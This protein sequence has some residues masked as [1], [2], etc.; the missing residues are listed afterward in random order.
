MA[1]FEVFINYYQGFLI[2]FFMNK[3]LVRQKIVS[4]WIDIASV[5]LIG[6]F[7]NV[8]Q[9]IPEKISDT[10]IFIF[11]FLHATITRRGGWWQRVLWTLICAAVMNVVIIFMTN[12]FLQNVTES[13]IMTPTSARVGYVIST[14]IVLTFVLM[15][16]AWIGAQQAIEF[17]TPSSVVALVGSFLMAFAAS[18]FLYLY[19][20]H[21]PENE[22]FLF[23]VY[24]CLLG[25]VILTLLLYYIIVHAARNQHMTEMQLQTMS[26]HTNHQQEMAAIYHDM[27]VMQHDMKHQVNAIMQ[28]IQNTPDVD[29][30]VVMALLQRSVPAVTLYM[31]GCTVVDAI[32]TAKHA[33]M[34]QHG[35]RFDFQPYPLQKLPLDDTAFCI[36]LSNIL[37][38]AIEG[39]QRIDDVSV[40]KEISLSFAR[41]W[42][43]FYLTCSNTMNPKT[44]QQV[45]DRFITSKAN[46]QIHGLGLESIHQIV[47]R[48]QGTCNISIEGLRFNIDIVLPDKEE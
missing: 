42:S 43:M 46:K 28:M 35:I 6:S 41:S 13:V 29:H 20:T 39:V 33:I 23:C 37:D 1:F 17:L 34:E 15:V 40:P 18:E 9:F 14:N 30:E 31:T 16:V 10:L 12:F 11:P 19:Q 8:C 26:L 2:I 47:A 25:L 36:L 7:L 45:E 44:I 3:V 22:T 4:K 32:L 48:I 24:I 21:K 5:L 27:L 38:N